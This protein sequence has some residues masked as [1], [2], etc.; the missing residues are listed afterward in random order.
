MVDLEVIKKNLEQV[1]KKLSDKEIIELEKK[2]QNEIKKA[3]CGFCQGEFSEE[4]I[5]TKK[6]A[7]MFSCPPSDSRYYHPDCLELRREKKANPLL[8]AKVERLERELEQ[9]RKRVEQ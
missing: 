2:R 6:Y 4:D 9:I 5:K 1:G 7:I 3:K 8:F